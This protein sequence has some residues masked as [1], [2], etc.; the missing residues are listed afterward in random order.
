[1]TWFFLLTVTAPNYPGL[2]SRSGMLQG[3]MLW[4]ERSSLLAWSS[5]TCKMLWRGFA[6]PLF[7]SFWL[8]YGNIWLIQY[9][10]RWFGATITLSEKSLLGAM[11]AGHVQLCFSFLKSKYS[12]RYHLHRVMIPIC[13][14]FF[15]WVRGEKL[16]CEEMRERMSILY[17]ESL[18]VTLAHVCSCCETSLPWQ[19]GGNRDKCNGGKCIYDY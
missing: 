2:C 16:R 4:E 1:M 8:K 6:I 7:F 10:E 15:L 17:A 18:H 5:L 12:Q 14:F 11:T 3:R 9:L 19:N 13:T